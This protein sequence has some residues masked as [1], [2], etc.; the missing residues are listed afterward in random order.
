ME[1]VGKVM[2]SPLLA[3][4]PIS[5]RFAEKLGIAEEA[6]I[7]P[8]IQ[9]EDKFQVV[10]NQIKDL[11]TRV[12]QQLEELK[13]GWERLPGAAGKRDSDPQPSIVEKIIKKHPELVKSNPSMLEKYEIY[14]RNVKKMSEEEVDNI[15]MPLWSNY[16]NGEKASDPGKDSTYQKNMKRTTETDPLLTAVEKLAGMIE[17]MNKPKTVIR[18]ED[19]KITGVA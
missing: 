14:L 2:A 6:P 7:E 3:G 16:L 11:E 13:Q 15:M 17:G 12:N 4:I 18:D 1:T 19:G 5:S 9:E 10:D 8:V